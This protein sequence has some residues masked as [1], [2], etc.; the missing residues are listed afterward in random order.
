MFI[1]FYTY[2]IWD[3]MICYSYTYGTNGIAPDTDYRVSYLNEEKIRE[4]IVKSIIPQEFLE[5]K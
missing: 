4:D 3:F 2:S 1:T 5:N